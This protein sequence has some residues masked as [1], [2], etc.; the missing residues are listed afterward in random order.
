[1]RIPVLNFYHFRSRSKERVASDIVIF[2]SNPKSLCHP[3]VF[4]YIVNKE[5]R[6]GLDSNVVAAVLKDKRLP[7]RGLY[8][9]EQGANSK[10]SLKSSSH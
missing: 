1:M 9:Q 6:E 4:C 8:G 10:A 2:D 7:G 5:R 3:P